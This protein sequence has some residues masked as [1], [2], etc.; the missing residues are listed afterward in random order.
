MR[1]AAFGNGGEAA[2]LA[3]GIAR[4]LSV[5]RALVRGGRQVDLAGI[6]D[7]VGRL[8]AKSL[9]L[10]PAEARAM[11]PALEEVRLQLDALTGAMLAAAGDCS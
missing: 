1:M 8:C 4:S 5:A 7:G 10:E 3:D 11:L 6:Q 9:D 2:R